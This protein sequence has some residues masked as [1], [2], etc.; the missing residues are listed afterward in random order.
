MRSTTLEMIHEHLDAFAER[1]SLIDQLVEGWGRVWGRYWK[2]WV[3][4]ELG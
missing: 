3:A 1:K 2:R 4:A